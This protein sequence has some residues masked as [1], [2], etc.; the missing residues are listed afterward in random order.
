[1]IIIILYYPGQKSSIK[2]NFV[3]VQN[4]QFKLTMNGCL[5]YESTSL[6]VLAYLTKFYP[7]IFS[8]LNIFIANSFEF[9][10][11]FTRQTSPKLP[12]PNI[13]KGIKFYGPTFSSESDYDDTDG[14]LGG[15]VSPAVRYSAVPEL[16]VYLTKIFYSSSTCLAFSSFNTYDSNILIYLFLALNLSVLSSIFHYYF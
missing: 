4:A 14:C 10:F 8:L 15:I 12:L 7:I 16:D 3:L 13:F 9:L 6:S 5:V 2:N 11:S 1:M